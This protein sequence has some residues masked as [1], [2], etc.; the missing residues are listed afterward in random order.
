[1]LKPADLLSWNADLGYGFFPVHPGE[2]PYDA[3]Y[4]RKYEDMGKTGMAKR[5][6]F[7]RVAIA[8]KAASLVEQA[9][10][11][12][13]FLDIGPGDGAYMRELS[14]DLP[15]AEDFSFGFDINPVMIERLKSEARW[16]DP[17]TRFLPQ[18][19]WHVM[20]FWDSFEHIHRPDLTVLNTR[21]VA[22]SIPVFQ[23]REHVLASKHFRP[24]EHVWYFTDGGI[25]TFMKRC[26]FSC[27]HDDDRET[28]L[29]REDIKSYIF[30]RD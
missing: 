14:K 1:M 9:G 25:K 30:V 21:S 26:G 8:V 18:H 5:L 22:M 29:G 23:N 12:H 15:E 10:H 4:V 3:E 27:V 28:Q 11:A 2:W 24:D 20:T 13:T 7:H 16:G 6:N 17:G 19:S